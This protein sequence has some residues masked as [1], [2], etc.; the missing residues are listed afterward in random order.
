MKP[1][2]PQPFSLQPA[3]PAAPVPRD[4]DC[5]GCVSDDTQRRMTVSRRIITSDDQETAASRLSQGL[6][7]RF[8]HGR[9]V[10]IPLTFR[11]QEQRGYYLRILAPQHTRPGETIRVDLVGRNQANQRLFGGIAVEIRVH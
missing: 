4:L 7:V 1:M 10:Q 5:A 2:S 8:P 6:E 9:V 3:V 11:P